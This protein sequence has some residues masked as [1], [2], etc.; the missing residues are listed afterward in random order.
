M[1]RWDWVPKALVA[2]AAF[3]SLYVL[4]R[5]ASRAWGARWQAFR[6][7]PVW[8]QAAVALAL[9][10]IALRVARLGWR[11]LLIYAGALAVLAVW[12]EIAAHDRRRAGQRGN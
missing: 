2:L 9:L 12:G 1:T 3:G 6:R 8:L 5:L 11:A 10:W 7:Q 4:G